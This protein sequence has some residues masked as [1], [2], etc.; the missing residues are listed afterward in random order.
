[1]RPPEWKPA[2]AGRVADC[3]LSARQC[4]TLCVIRH[5]AAGGSPTRGCGDVRTTLCAAGSV[6]KPACL[7]ANETEP[8]RQCAASHVPRTGSPP[9]RRQTA[10]P[11]S[12]IAWMPGTK[13]PVITEMLWPMP[14][15][16]APDMAQIRVLYPHTG[17]G[18]GRRQAA[19][20]ATRGAA[21]RPRRAGAP[22][23]GGRGPPGPPARRPAAAAAGRA[24]G[25]SRSAPSTSRRA[26]SRRR[27]WRTI[28]RS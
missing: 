24:P 4:G 17:A 2:L 19:R 13:T 25:S 27:A 11:P 10:L 7:P 6:A 16:V 5:A 28:S 15:A 12:N 20:G 8:L 3:S 1:M 23:E 21:P 26:K 22:G 9:G 14:T 18:G